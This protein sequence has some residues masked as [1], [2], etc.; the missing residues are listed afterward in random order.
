[1]N[2]DLKR[3]TEQVLNDLPPPPSQPASHIQRVSI[4][5]Q[6]RDIV[7]AALIGEAGGEG[8]RG[9]QAV[10]NV[11]SNR[12]RG[13]P[14]RFAD[15]VLLPKQFSYFNNKTPQE[16]VKRAK[17]HQRWSEAVGVVKQAEN[18]QL[19]DITGGSDHYFNPVKANP[20][21]AKSMRLMVRIGNHDFYKS[22]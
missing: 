21:W 22:R 14:D 5:Q 18:G 20:S 17:T 13:R 12:S 3:L 4:S 7:A 15:V 19:R 8:L 16:A 2:Q 10:M 1:V 6:D 11:I 9:L